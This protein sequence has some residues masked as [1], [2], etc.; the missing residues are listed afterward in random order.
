MGARLSA[1]VCVCIQDRKEETQLHRKRL[2][3]KAFKYMNTNTSNIYLQQ[4]RI[5]ISSSNVKH[6]VK[7][8]SV[9]KFE[10]TQFQKDIGCSECSQPVGNSLEKSDS[11]FSSMAE[12]KKTNH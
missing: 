5:R 4:Q 9:D 7:I 6:I 11:L 8:L 12:T 2:K 3:Q 10:V 1:F